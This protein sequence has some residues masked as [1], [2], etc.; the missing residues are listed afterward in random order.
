MRLIFIIDKLDRMN[1][2]DFTRN[3]I[4][5]LPKAKAFGLVKARLIRLSQSICSIGLATLRIYTG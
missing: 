5:Q 3:P 2:F 4:S 1:N